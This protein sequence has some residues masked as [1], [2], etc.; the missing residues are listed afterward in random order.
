VRL[1]C[2][3]LDKCV[4]KRQMHLNTKRKV[5]FRRYSPNAQL[6]FFRKR[7]SQYKQVLAAQA[8]RNKLPD[9]KRDKIACVRMIEEDMG[10]DAD[11]SD[12]KCEMNI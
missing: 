5:Y 11:L 3:K 9:P 8:L 6:M 2:P 7:E 4:S 10:E 1:R 12:L